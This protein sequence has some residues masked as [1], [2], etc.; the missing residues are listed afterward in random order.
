[1]VYVY[2][3]ELVINGRCTIARCR[4]GECIFIGENKRISMVAYPIDKD[5]FN[6]TFLYIPRNF[7]CGFYHTLDENRISQEAMSVSKSPC[8]LAPTPEIT[9]LFESLMPYFNAAVEIPVELVRLKIV[10]GVYALL[11]ADS[12]FYPILFDFAYFNHIDILDFLNE[13]P[14][15]PM[16]WR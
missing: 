4:K 7:L 2:S 13:Q 5:D 16:Q 14:V 6:A 12:E 11:N 9:S 1:M 3:G 10:E 15:T 8:K